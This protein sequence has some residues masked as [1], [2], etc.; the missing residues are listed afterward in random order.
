MPAQIGYFDTLKS[1]AG[2]VFTYLASI[3]LTGTDGRTLT[4][5]ADSFVNQDLTTD[6]G[7]SWDHLHITGADGVVATAAAASIAAKNP[8]NTGIYNVGTT[9]TVSVL[10]NKTITFTLA[11]AGAMFVVYDDSA[12]TS[13]AFFASYASATITKLSDPGSRFEITDTDT[14]LI[15][16]F[17]SANNLTINIKNYTNVTKLIGCFVFGKVTSATA[18]A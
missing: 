12:G 10:D 4:V 1:V 11:V 14:G 3:T 8:T 9:G 16:V 5:E 2:K 15:A 17:K 13:A 7:P 6:F 18:P